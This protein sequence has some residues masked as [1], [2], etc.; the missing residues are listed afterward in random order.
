MNGVDSLNGICCSAAKS[1]MN[2]IDYVYRTA[3]EW[4]DGETKDLIKNYLNTDKV[5]TS[6]EGKYYYE[7]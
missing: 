3:N 2:R 5:S 7:F 1:L 4:M 6:I